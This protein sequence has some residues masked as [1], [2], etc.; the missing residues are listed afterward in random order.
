MLIHE[1]YV[2]EPQIK[3]KFQVPD[4]GKWNKIN[5]KKKAAI[6][7]SSKLRF[8]INTWRSYISINENYA[9]LTKG[10][11]Q[12]TTISSIRSTIVASVTS[13]VNHRLCDIAPLSCV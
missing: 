9:Q 6:T 2:F 1:N 13:R 7:Q 12:I 3:M 8:N 11:Y 4:P 10:Y 5:E